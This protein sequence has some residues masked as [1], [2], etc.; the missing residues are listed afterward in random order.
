MEAVTRAGHRAGARVGWDLA[1]A[2]GN[3]PTR[4][5]DI[6]ADF[7][8]WCSY[9]YLNAG[10]GAIAGAFVHEKHHRAAL[11]QFAGWWGNDPA[12]RFR[13]GPEFEPVASADRWA[14]SNPPIF[15]LTPLKSSLALFDRAGM[16]ALRAKSLALTAYMEGL[17][18]ALAPRVRVRTPSDPAQRGCQLSLVVPGSSRELQRA[19]LVRGIV[20]DFREPDVM[21]AAPAPLYNTFH[22]VWRFVREL[23]NL[24]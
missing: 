19:L 18:T 6:G 15:S 1:H 9:K 21:R 4:L 23:G 3:V 11:P 2:A 7:A 5:H 14:L 13:M 22:D 20:C 24:T 16:G 12:S 8:A 10:P 17:I